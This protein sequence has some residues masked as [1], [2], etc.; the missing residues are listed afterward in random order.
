[1]RFRWALILVIAMTMATPA[2]AEFYRYRDKN[3]TVRFTDNLTEVPPEQRANLKAYRETV[4]PAPSRTADEADASVQLPEPET[5]DAE[6]DEDRKAA[7]ETAAR[8]RQRQEALI[9]EYEALQKERAALAKRDGQRVNNAQQAR[10]AE[11]VE[12]LN[13]KIRDYQQ[14]REAYEQ[15]VQAHN[16]RMARQAAAETAPATE[17]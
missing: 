6:V 15:E 17:P 10:Y 4:S 13:A 2:A 7:E 11:A 16:A 12:A 3:G 14:R 1:M 9:R 8:L 5:T